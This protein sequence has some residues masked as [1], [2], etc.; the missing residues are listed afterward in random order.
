MAAAWVVSRCA[1]PPPGR[2][3]SLDQPAVL[4]Y[5]LLWLLQSCATSCSSAL[6]NS[7]RGCL[8]VTLSTLNRHCLATRADVGTPKAV[9][10]AQHFAGAAL[11]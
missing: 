7:V 4:E 9:C 1:R 5:Q 6:W 3:S 8:Q 10:L 11:C 2:P